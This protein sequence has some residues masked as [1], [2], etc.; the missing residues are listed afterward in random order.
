MFIQIACLAKRAAIYCAVTGYVRFAMIVQNTAPSLDAE[1][2]LP[3]PD[4]LAVL[5]DRLSRDGVAVANRSEHLLLAHRN[6]SQFAAELLALPIKEREFMPAESYF[7]EETKGKWIPG[8]DWLLRKASF[9]FDHEITGRSAYHDLLRPDFLNDGV[10]VEF[11]R[12]LNLP[13]E[14]IEIP[15]FQLNWMTKAE[16]KNPDFI[17]SHTH[18]NES[19]ARR[20]S[21]IYNAVFSLLP[22]Q[23]GG[24]YYL[25][26]D[27]NGT[28][29]VET[30]TL[31]AG[32][33][34]I[35]DM[36]RNGGYHGVTQINAGTRL[37]AVWFLGI[38]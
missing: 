16:N 18:V 25:C 19:W 2:K 34:L 6:L 12:L 33:L 32:D 21:T 26:A 36:N 15:R 14:Q 11:G 38:K 3:S 37:T 27:V 5:A 8:I 10:K 24:D 7:W 9:A 23:S 17:G 31:P 35:S 22:A 13:V 1:I 30:F 4:T 20:Y 28:K 29:D